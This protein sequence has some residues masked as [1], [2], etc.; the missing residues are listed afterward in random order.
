M[1]VGLS[2]STP[3][4]NTYSFANGIGKVFTSLFDG[5][6]PHALAFQ[7]L[8]P[9]VKLI[10]F[11]ST[12][13]GILIDLTHLTEVIGELFILLTSLIQSIL[14]IWVETQS[15]TLESTPWATYGNAF[16]ARLVDWNFACSQTDAHKS[17]E[18]QRQ[19][20]FHGDSLSL[21]LIDD[22]SKSNCAFG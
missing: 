17:D 9:K 18:T 10:A 6:L 16:N 11:T 12:G 14:E 22:Y 15:G 4:L 13:S 5:S 1:R 3:S 21:F 7:A 2:P 19:S 8:S 20:N